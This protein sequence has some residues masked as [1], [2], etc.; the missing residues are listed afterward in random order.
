MKTR[1]VKGRELQ[2]SRS[3]LRR[4]R[5]GLGRRVFLT[6]GGRLARRVPALVAVLFI[7]IVSVTASATEGG[8]TSKAL[9]VDT[10]M[11]GVQPPPGLRLTTFLARYDTDHTLDS[12]G[13]DRAG[14]SNF[15]VYANAVTF[16]FQYVWKGVELW[17]ANIET[18][19]GISVYV[20]ADVRFDV[21]TPRGPL[22][23]ESSARG[24]GDALFAPVILGWHGERFHQMVGPEFFLPTGKFD[25]NK[26]ANTS[27]GYY[28]AGPGYWFTWFPTDAIEVSGT[29]VYLINGK[30]SDTNYKSG[31]ELSF[32]YGVGYGLTHAW[33]IGASGYLYKQI[34]DDKQNGQTVADGNRGQAVAIG[35]F[36]RYHPSK[37]WGITLKWQHETSVENRTRGDRIFLQFALK[38]W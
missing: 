36:L 13:N 2:F 14:L 9:G 24:I 19:L 16:R 33:Q 25:K 35:P 5:N 18:R 30:N 7:A 10:V 22:H 28:S 38:L 17:G 23:R 21:R 26:L 32:D 6:D 37:D 3:W 31:N 34:A 11:A 12:S 20:D 29:G 27:R 4:V 8:G 1:G 15:D